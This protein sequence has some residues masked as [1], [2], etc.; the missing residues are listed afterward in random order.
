MVL[1]NVDLLWI[2]YVIGTNYGIMEQTIV[3]YRKLWNV[4]FIRKKLC[5]NGKNF[6]TIVNDS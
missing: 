2:N 3:L 1:W 5:Y 4:D 6:G